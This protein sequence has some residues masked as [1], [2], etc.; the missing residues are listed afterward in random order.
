MTVQSSFSLLYDKYSHE[1]HI[2]V[3]LIK[4]TPWR[5]NHIIRLL[6]I[7]LSYCIVWYILWSHMTISSLTFCFVLQSPVST[8]MLWTSWI[9]SRKKRQA[10]FT[11][12]LSLAKPAVTIEIFSSNHSRCLVTLCEFSFLSGLNL[13]HNFCGTS[14]TWAHLENPCMIDI[15]INF[16]S[17]LAMTWYR[18]IKSK[19]KS[20][21]Y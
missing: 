8:V 2:L 21:H 3:Q 15:Q 11:S 4:H 20:M 18:L 1:I 17:K 10:S 12:L 5:M 16:G 14:P 19:T 7:L 6:Y 13:D 9:G